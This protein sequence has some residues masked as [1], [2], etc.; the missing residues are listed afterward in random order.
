MKIFILII[1][2]TILMVIVSFLFLAG[3]FLGKKIL[4]KGCNKTPCC[5][6]KKNCHENDNGKNIK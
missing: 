3:L 2:S 1:C 5:S 4:T 6:N